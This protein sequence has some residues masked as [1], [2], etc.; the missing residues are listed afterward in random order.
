L[1]SGNY[2]NL[3]ALRGEGKEYQRQDAKRP[4]QL[5]IQKPPPTFAFEDI[6]ASYVL[7]LPCTLGL[8]PLA[9][10]PSAY[11]A[12]SVVKFGIFLFFPG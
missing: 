8:E 10:I 1:R 2:K 9:I 6:L 5:F 12:I 7:I 11:S 3:C 4:Q